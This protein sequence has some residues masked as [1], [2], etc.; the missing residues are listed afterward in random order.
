MQSA[1]VNGPLLK[2]LED[3]LGPHVKVK[4]SSHYAF[5]VCGDIRIDR[6]TSCVVH[7]IYLRIV[8]MQPHL[9]I[10]VYIYFFKCIFFVA[11]TMVQL[12]DAA[13]P[14]YCHARPLPCA[15]LSAASPRSSSAL[16][17]MH[18]R[19]RDAVGLSASGGG[20]GQDEWPSE[21]C[22]QTR[23]LEMIM[24]RLWTV[25]FQRYFYQHD[26]LKCTREQPSSC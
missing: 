1:K 16:Q 26:L 22:L 8:W 25:F 11:Q 12:A 23:E 17:D 18:L 4:V 14:S 10:F 9:R 21:Q 3:K 5:V 6:A 7:G 20:A 13:L 19:V 24:V 2:S 15:V